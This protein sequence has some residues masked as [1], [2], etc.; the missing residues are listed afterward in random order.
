LAP[1]ITELLTQKLKRGQGRPHKSQGGGNK[2]SEEERL[3]LEAEKFT[4]PEIQ[5]RRTKQKKV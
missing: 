4:G 2:Y 1:E 5:E 3:Q